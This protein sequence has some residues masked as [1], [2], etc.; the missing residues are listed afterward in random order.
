[1]ILLPFFPVTLCL[2]TYGSG[3]CGASSCICEGQEYLGAE[4][5]TRRRIWDAMVDVGVFIQVEYYPNSRL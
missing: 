2:T 1:M 3:C 5:G 4:H